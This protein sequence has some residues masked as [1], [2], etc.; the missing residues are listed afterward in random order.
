[1]NTN[2]YA[3]GLGKIEVK[4]SLNEPFEASIE[5]T[6]AMDFDQSQIIAR[7]ASD[8]DFERMGVSREGVLSQL[9]FEPDLKLKPPAI[10]IRSNKPIREPV[11]N[12]ILNVQSPKGQMMKEYSVFLNPAK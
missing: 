4:S 6:G 3:F 1:V 5:L 10:I 8:A 11:L 7:L 2:V 12:F 9:T